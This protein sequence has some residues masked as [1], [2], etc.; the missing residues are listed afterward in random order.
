MT[1]DPSGLDELEGPEVDRLAAG[2][3]GVHRTLETG[4]RAVARIEARLAQAVI[5]AVRVGGR[6]GVQAVRMRQAAVA[7]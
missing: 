4:A 1:F 3:V 5:R 6:V 2:T 7:E